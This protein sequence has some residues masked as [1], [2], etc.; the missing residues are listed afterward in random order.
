MRS[1]LNNPF[2]FQTIKPKEAEDD[3]D[4][5]DCPE[6]QR[7]LIREAKEEISSDDYIPLPTAF[8][9]NEYHIMKEF[10]WTVQ[11]EEDRDNLLYTISGR[12]AFRRFKDAIRLLRIEDDWYSFRQEEFEKIAIR[13]LEANGMAYTRAAEVT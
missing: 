11:D 13:W 5:S 8:D 6:W 7:E 12:G 3:V 2:C 10:C 9:I 4:P 1:S